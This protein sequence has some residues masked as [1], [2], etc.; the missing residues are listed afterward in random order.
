MIT[1]NGEWYNF[2][3]YYPTYASDTAALL[4]SIEDVGLK[5]TLS[6]MNGM[7]AFGLYD[8][9]EQKIHLIVDRFAQKPLYYIND[10]GFAFAS[11]PAALLKW[12][13]KWSIDE[14]ALASFWKLGSV[15]YDSIWSGIKKVNAAEHLVYDIASGD[16]KVSRYWE[17]EYDADVVNMEGLITDAIDCTKVSDVPVYIF[18]SG[19]IDSTLVASRFIGGNAI[20]L[21]SPE[22]LYAQEAA[23]KFEI[24]LHN[25][26]PATIKPVMAMDDYCRK[27]GEPSMAGLIPWITSQEATKFCKVAVI[28]NGADELFFGYDRT[29]DKVSSI[30]LNHIF[31]SV[32]DCP[33]Y[34]PDIDERLSTGRWL[35]LMTYIQYD[36]NKTLDFASM[37]H[38]LEVR[39]PFLDHRLVEVALSIPAD[40]HGRKDIL[41]R[42]LHNLGF[43][44]EYTGRAKMGFSLYTQPDG[45]DTLQREA[46]EWCI[47]NK[48]LRLTG[49]PSKRDLMY[50]RA[51]AFGFKCW[52]ETW[53]G[54]IK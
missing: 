1:Y 23:N 10:G 46:Y 32:I 35:E 52:W 27:S 29:T 16:V 7:F 38:S 14:L 30:Q 42:M 44:K 47:K 15:M 6:R 48:W 37:A 34:K 26:T 28:A 17:P 3:D 12:K 40:V 24:N 9:L 2:K 45:L 22:L 8:K 43:S 11:S 20:H 49:Y 4:Q 54:K 31:R 39:S 41:K 13:D 25:V 19:G 33:I 18:L 50:L 36:L 53:E 5:A 21:Q 51:S